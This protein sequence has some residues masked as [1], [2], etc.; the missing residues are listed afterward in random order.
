MAWERCFL[1]LPTIMVAIAGNQNEICRQLDRLGAAICLGELKNLT[2]EKVEDAVTFALSNPE[3]MSRMADQC[4]EIM[5]KSGSGLK[6]F[7][8]AFLK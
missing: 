3:K 1:G 2:I 6:N 5:G 7:C 8:K 4:I